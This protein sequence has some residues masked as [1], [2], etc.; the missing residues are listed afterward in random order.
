M[1]EREYLGVI[2]S[3]GIHTALGQTLREKAVRERG[4][5]PPDSFETE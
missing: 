2:P 5:E 4:F 1:F 3:K